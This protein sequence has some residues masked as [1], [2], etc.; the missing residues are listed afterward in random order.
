M[1]KNTLLAV[2]LSM[3]LLLGFYFIQSIQIYRKRE[4]T[5][6]IEFAGAGI[7][8]GILGF[9]AAGMVN[10]S[11]VSVMPM[12]YGLLGTGIAINIMLRRNTG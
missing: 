1:N 2:V 8:L 7:F 12:F 9:S 3:V 4:Y 6:F 5:E 11:S 10:D